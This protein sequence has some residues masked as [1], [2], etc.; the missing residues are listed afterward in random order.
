M[1]QLTLV[2]G[3]KNYSSWSLRPWIAMKQ[4]DLDFQEIRILL[5]TP[6]THQEIRHYSPSGR[7]PVLLDDS[8][9]IWESLAICEY[10]AERFAPQLW[11]TDTR[12]RAIAR[13]ISAEMHSGFFSLRQSMPMDCRSRFPGMGRNPS[14]QADINRVTEIWRDCRQQFGGEG[15]F[16]FGDFSIAD[17]MFAPVV[18][19]F[20][21]YDV[22]LGRI[23][24]EYAQKIWELP[25]MQEWLQDASQEVEVITM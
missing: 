17:A 14:V 19:R 13:S 6:K 25:A 22:A 16:L 2:I 10:I 18:S 15:D 11:P 24:G 23:A 20:V 8:L 4:A 5:D 9:P 7:V 12:A 1:R 21:T 3:N